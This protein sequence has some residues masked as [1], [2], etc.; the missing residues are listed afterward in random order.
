VTLLVKG[1]EI[2]LEADAYA[3]SP[4]LLMEVPLSTQPVER[5][6]AEE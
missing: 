3:Q 1:D 6:A 2:P 4:P 5:D